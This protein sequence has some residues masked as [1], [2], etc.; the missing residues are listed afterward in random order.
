MAIS[1]V[2]AVRSV[3]F[4]FVTLNTSISTKAKEERWNFEGDIALH[5]HD[6]VLRGGPVGTLPCEEGL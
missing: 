4:G 6:S 2:G 5:L 1:G 3:M